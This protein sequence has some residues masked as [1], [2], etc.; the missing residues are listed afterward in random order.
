MN[1]KNLEKKPEVFRFA[2]L[3][4]YTA[5]QK[6]LIHSINFS[7]YLVTLLIGRTVRFEISGATKSGGWKY[8]QRRTADKPPGIAV[9]WHNQILLTSYFWRDSNFAAM[10]SASFD[11]EYIARMLQRLGIGAIRGS[12]SRGGTGALRRMARLLKKEKISL[13]IAV[14]GP[15]GPRYEAKPGAVLLAKMTGVPIIPVAIVPEK[16]RTVGSWDQMQ[17]PKLFTRARVSVGEPIFVSRE[18]SDRELA[19]KLSEV[20]ARLDELTALGE[21]RQGG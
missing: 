17:I 20:Q 14:D 21:N 7:L 4:K 15:R 12:S 19:E 8:M 5:K 1:S 2:P 16:F 18:A 11:G 6:I 10:V 9:F 3:S 13:T